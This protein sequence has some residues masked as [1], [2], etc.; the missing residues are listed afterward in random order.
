MAGRGVEFVAVPAAV[1]FV[2]ECVRVSAED[3]CC[4]TTDQ[5]VSEFGVLVGVGHLIAVVVRAADAAGAGQVRRVD[6]EQGVAVLAEGFDE[7]EGR[8]VLQ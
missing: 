1:E 4:A 5:G 7:L 8:T 6:V 2:V 3:N